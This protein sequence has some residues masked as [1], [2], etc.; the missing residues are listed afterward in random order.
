MATPPGRVRRMCTRPAS[1]SNTIDSGGVP[2]RAASTSAVPMLGCPANGISAVGTKMR[3]RAVWA[4]SAG[5]RTKVVS[6]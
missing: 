5:G 2:M 3:T 1:S 6:L 4:G